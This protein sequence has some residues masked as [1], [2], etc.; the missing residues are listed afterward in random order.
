MGRK[1]GKVKHWKVQIGPE[2]V[3][4]IEPI[5]C[6]SLYLGYGPMGVLLVL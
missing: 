2:F 3:I 5:P 1:S 6:Y 4:C